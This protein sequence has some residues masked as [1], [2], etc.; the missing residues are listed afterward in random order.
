[1]VNQIV[2]ATRKSSVTLVWGGLERLSSSSLGTAQP[3]SGFSSKLEIYWAL[4]SPLSPSFA[5]FLFC[6]SEPRPSSAFYS[7][8]DTVKRHRTFLL[9]AFSQTFLLSSSMNSKAG[10][11]CLRNVSASGWWPPP[12]C[13]TVLFLWRGQTLDGPSVLCKREI[14]SR[15]SVELEIRVQQA[16]SL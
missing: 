6:P 5:C 15:A 2:L 14:K 16:S 4:T 7:H 11:I 3:H 10:S 8:W 13:C 1:M 9:T 12:H